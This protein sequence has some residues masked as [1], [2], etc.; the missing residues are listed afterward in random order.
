MP[1]CIKS[2]EVV[3]EG[4]AGTTVALK[5]ADE[6]PAPKINRVGDN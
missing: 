2:A 1:I 5:S 4:G 3:I 6:T